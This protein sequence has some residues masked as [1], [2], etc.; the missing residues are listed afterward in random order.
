MGDKK[1]EIKI[2][3]KNTWLKYEDWIHREEYTKFKQVKWMESTGNGWLIK[4]M[5]D[6]RG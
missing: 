2:V 6:A 4:F 5:N 3:D 1:V